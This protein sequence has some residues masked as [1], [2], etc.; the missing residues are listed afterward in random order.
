METEE[1]TVRIE[2]PARGVLTLADRPW[3]CSLI[4]SEDE[5]EP[6]IIRG[7]D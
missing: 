3:Y 6:E 2:H 7:Y 5:R 1:L 4:A